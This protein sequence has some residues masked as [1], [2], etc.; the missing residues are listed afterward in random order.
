MGRRRRSGVSGM[1]DE[2]QGGEAHITAGRPQRGEA[3]FLPAWRA[4]CVAYRAVRREGGKDE[5]AFRKALE[6]FEGE[7]PDL[8]GKAAAEQV[9]RAINYASVEHAEW[10]WNGVGEGRGSGE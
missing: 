7:R 6:A 2:G 4:A 10:F 1:A 8:K 5:E 9:S 3:E